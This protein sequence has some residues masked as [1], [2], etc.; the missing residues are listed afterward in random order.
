MKKILLFAALT[1]IT[2]TALLVSSCKKDE[3][4]SGTDLTTT[5]VGNYKGSLLTDS[6]MGT[7]G[8]TWTPP[9]YKL[10]VTK[11]DNNHIHFANTIDNDATEF[12]AKVES[13]STYGVAVFTIPS[14]SAGGKTWAGQNTTN[15]QF[16]P[17]GGFTGLSYTLKSTTNDIEAFTGI[18]D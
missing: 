15:N 8:S 18:N 3:E 9:T 17:G 14:F 4:E 12:T 6:V 11:V 7:A 16:I 1:L 2:A 5:L 13:V 10:T